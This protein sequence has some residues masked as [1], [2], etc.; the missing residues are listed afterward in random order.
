MFVKVYPW[1]NLFYEASH[2]ATRLLYLNGQ[3]NFFSP[4]LL[5]ERTM[6]V[7]VDDEVVVGSL[8]DAK[9]AVNK[10]VSRKRRLQLAVVAK[11]PWP[12]SRIMAALLRSGF[13]LSDASGYFIPAL[14]FFFRYR[15]NLD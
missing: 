5:L 14:V 8:H 10:E 4:W 12:L 1:L 11:M 6:L 2:F 7:Q 15:L 9:E 13:T 3:S